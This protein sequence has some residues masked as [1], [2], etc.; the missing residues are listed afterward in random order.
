MTYLSECIL[1]NLDELK[2]LRESEIGPLKSIMTLQRI[3]V[4]RP[5]DRLAQD[6]VRRASFVGSINQTEFLN[7][8]TGSR[9]FLTFE[10]E[11]VDLGAL[12]DIDTVMAQAYTLCRNGERWRYDEA[13]IAGI[14]ERNKKFSICGHEE[15]LLLE[16]VPAPVKIQ[17]LT[18]WLIATQIAQRIKGKRD[19]FKVDKASVREIGTALV[20]SKYPSKKAKGVKLYAVG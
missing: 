10:V 20:K 2:T 5:Y 3:K 11:A 7:D 8:P 17:T 1:I 14:N 18:E 9:R 19:D 4:R 16:L 13:E 12:P 6:M 15:E